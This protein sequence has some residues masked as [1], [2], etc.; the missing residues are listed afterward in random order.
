MARA[1]DSSLTP[2]GLFRVLSWVR[3]NQKVKGVPD[4]V[5]DPRSELLEG[6]TAHG[7]ATLPFPTQPLMNSSFWGQT[8]PCIQP[9]PHTCSVTSGQWLIL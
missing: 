9:E 4:W 8:Y 7:K 5:G 6:F 2:G 3:R 1:P